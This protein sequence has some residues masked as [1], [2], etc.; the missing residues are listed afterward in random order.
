MKEPFTGAG[1]TIGVGSL[2]VCLGIA[3][4]SCAASGIQIRVV[5]TASAPVTNLT[6]SYAGGT[7]TLDRLGAGETYRAGIHPTGPTDVDVQF[8]LPGGE[9]K[10]QKLRAQLEPTLRGSVALTI[11]PEGGIGWESHL[12]PRSTRPPP[13]GTLAV[14][15]N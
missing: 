11:T 9:K 1:R 2:T 3:L 15:G 8:L 4:V 12:S 10:S 7:L 6:L 5:N 14:P 13:K